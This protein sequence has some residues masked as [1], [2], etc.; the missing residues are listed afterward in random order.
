MPKLK[1]TIVKRKGSS[2]DWRDFRCAC[3]VVHLSETQRIEGPLGVVQHPLY[4]AFRTA[5]SG[6]TWDG[7]QHRT[8]YEIVIGTADYP[9]II[10]AMCDVD[11]P[12]ALAAMSAELASR[13]SCD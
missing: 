6:R 3:E 8:D 7:K 13:L 10:K 1:D 2:Q 5:A 9:A 11:E 4:L 12:A